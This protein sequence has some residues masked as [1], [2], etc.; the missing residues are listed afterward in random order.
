MSVTDNGIGIA[1]AMQAKIFERFTQASEE[2]AQRYGG[3]GLGLAI[4]KHLVEKIGG[5]IGV[6]SEV[7]RG[8]CFWFEVDVAAGC[9]LPSA[10]TPIRWQG[11]ALDILVV[12]DVALNREVAEGLLQRDG[13]QVWL[14]EDAEQA[15]A[16]CAAQ[17]LRSDTAGCASAGD[18]WRASYANRSAATTGR[19]GTRASSP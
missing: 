10:P 5:C 9:R 17:R 8:S 19:T 14:A 18:E 15:L 13:H 16:Q 12:E 1:P 2:V 7:G 4:C 6:S 11:P 3:T